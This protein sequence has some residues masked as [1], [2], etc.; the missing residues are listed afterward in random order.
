[1][2]GYGVNQRRARRN[3]RQEMTRLDVIENETKVQ[4]AYKAW[5]EADEQAVEVSTARELAKRLKEA[6]QE[7]SN[8]Y[9]SDDA[10]TE[11][12]VFRLY[13]SAKAIIEC[14]DDF[15]GDM[16]G[17]YTMAVHDAYASWANKRVSGK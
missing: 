11:V 5:S 2:V 8:S 4:E 16:D 17:H 9:P 3:P 14:Y 13:R 15:N 1:M 12:A 6:A 7:C 10:P